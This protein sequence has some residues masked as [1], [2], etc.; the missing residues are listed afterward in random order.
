MWCTSLGGGLRLWTVAVGENWCEDGIEWCENMGMH[1]VF[2]ET[3]RFDFLSNHKPLS[4]SRPI[5]SNPV[6]HVHKI[7]AADSFSE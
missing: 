6:W 4:D 2:P 7:Q 5:G 1:L 3:V